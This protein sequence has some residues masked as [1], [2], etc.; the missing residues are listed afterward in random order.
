MSASNPP[1]APMIAVKRL[2]LV[3]LAVAVGIILVTHVGRWIDN[4]F[5][6]L[7]GNALRRQGA[8]PIAQDVV[9]VGI[10]EAFL[11]SVPEPLTLSHPYLGRFLEAM[12]AVK[13]KVV[14]LDLVL[15]EKSFR[16]LART[17]KSEENLD[18]P[19]LR[20]LIA[21]RRSTHLVLGTT[22]EPRLN[23][24]RLVFVDF[25]AASG[26]QMASLMT[27]PDEDGIL[28]RLPGAS[29]QPSEM[30]ALYQAMAGIAPSA[31]A[32]GSAGRVNYT[33]GL[34][35]SYVPLQ[36]VLRDFDNN[37]LDAL[38]RRFADRIVLLGAVLPYEDRVSLPAA[39]AAF[40]PRELNVPG[41]LFQ[42]QALRTVINDATIR[43]ANAALMFVLGIAALGFWFIPG[44]R[45]SAALYLFAS[46]VLIVAAVFA[47]RHNLFLAIG[48]PLLIGGVAV[49]ARAFTQAWNAHQEKRLLRRAFGGSVSP[50][51]LEG[52]LT[53]KISSELAGQRVHVC[54][55][56]A[57]IRNFTT[58]SESMAP[59]AVIA[60]LNRYFQ[61]I[62]AV[63]HRHQGTVDKFIGDG[64]MAF[65]GAPCALPVPEINAFEAAHEMLRELEQLNAELLVEN[66]EPIH[67]GIGLH[68]GDAVIGYLGSDAKNEYTAIGDTVNAA[69]R[70]EGLTKEVGYTIV[71]SDAVAAALNHPPE[72]ADLGSLPIK[73][74]SP[75]KIYGLAVKTGDE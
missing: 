30:S 49:A 52:I 23:G 11:R 65:F 21:A 56:F 64:I 26:G 35:H 18:Q 70:L 16:F 24:F 5:F 20:G 58:R 3:V 71:V 6:D 50:S 2:T 7:A 27:C 66:I 48:N 72:L 63:I 17:G 8:Q 45:K 15:P 9:I 61:R 4:Q 44:T 37:N 12:G 60:M 59:E 31:D 22:W 47:L 25:I 46:S 51:V 34:P 40:E 28:R 33:I 43:E 36:E 67:I 54:I 62:T 53:G 10:D 19:L 55:L 75:M 13:P 69:S 1:Q 32:E 42:A 74:R 41:I 57:D 68:A 14:G 73:G 39:I 29:C 38:R